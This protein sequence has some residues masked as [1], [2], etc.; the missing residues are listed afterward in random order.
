ML[1]LNKKSLIVRGSEL[2]AFVNH[3]LLG[4]AELM[5]D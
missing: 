2:S 1:Y 5:N 3:P 4:G